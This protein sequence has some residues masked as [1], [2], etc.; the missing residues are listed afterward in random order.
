VTRGD[1]YVAIRGEK[2]N[3]HGFIR[4]AVRNG[5]TAVIV[6]DDGA[7]P[8]SFFTLE[9]VVKIVVP[10]SR[11]AMALSARNFY[12]NPSERLRLV[13]ITGTNGKTTTTHLVRSILEASGQRVGF[14]GTMGHHDGVNAIE[15]THTTPESPELN[16]IL[17][18]MVANGCSAAVMEVSS[19]SLVLDRVYGLKFAA[20]A[21]TNLTQDHLDFHRTMEEYFRAKKMLF[22][23]LDEDAVAVTNIDDPFGERMVDGTS[24]RTIRYSTTE[25]ADIT[26]RGI[27]TSLHGTTITLGYGEVTQQIA[28]PLIG[29]FNVS[30]ILTAA[31]VSAGLG[32]APEAVATGIS[33]L[34]SVRGRFEPI[35]SEQGWVAVIDY[36]H[37]PDAL[38]NTLKTITELL[39][40]GDGQVITIFGCGGDRDRTK[41][42][43]MG[44]IATRMSDV[45]IVTSDNPRSENPDSIID[46]ILQGSTPGANVSREPDRRKAILRGLGMA[47]RGDVVLIAGKG[48]EIYQIIGETK[49]HLDDREEVLKFLGK[50][51]N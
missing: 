36:A 21:F 17:S 35:Q 5:A 22:D 16:E 51:W 6:E 15:A 37:T 45:T 38:E 20:A 34:R 41:R 33:S 13:G 2:T 9:G 47:R 7:L 8:D 3:G 29:R 44:G 39:G 27:E 50:E 42:P 24:A 26:A 11:K 19:H 4:E 10:A 18:S 46:E 48:H 23:G 28:S 32:I 25:E 1:L 40:E 14:I 12:G 30:N 43:I 49:T 31:G